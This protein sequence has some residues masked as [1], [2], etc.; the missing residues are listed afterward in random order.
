MKQLM[1]ME[2]TYILPTLLIA[3]QIDFVIMPD[4]ELEVY[5]V[6]FE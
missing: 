6:E 3:S 5:I 1:R 4:E 2:L